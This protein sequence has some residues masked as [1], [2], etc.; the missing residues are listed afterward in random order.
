ME[1]LFLTLIGATLFSQSWHLLGLYPDGRT[2]GVFTSVLGLATLITLTIS[3]MLLTGIDID[4]NQLESNLNSG[5]IMVMKMLIIV[6]ASYSIGIGIQGLLDLDERA[7]GF[8][9][10]T[11]TAASIVALF[12][13]AGTLGG[14]YG[15]SVIVSMSAASLILA[16]LGGMIFF[17][18]AIPFNA[19]RAVAGWFLLVG[20]F[21]LAAIGLGILTTV[22]RIS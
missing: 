7:V 10:A 14:R 15:D 17:H 4:G 2:M 20:S 22:I 16:T 1:G 5:E 19:L 21:I 3:P 13:F 12:Y 8:F 11:V 9:S 18:T 6:W